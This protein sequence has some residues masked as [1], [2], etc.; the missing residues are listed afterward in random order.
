MEDC[1]S[2][3]IFPW[4]HREAGEASLHNIAFWSWCSVFH[5]QST[6]LLLLP[7]RS[8][9]KLFSFAI[10]C[11]TDCPWRNRGVLPLSALLLGFGAVVTESHLIAFHYTPKKSS[12]FWNSCRISLQCFTRFSFSNGKRVLGTQRAVTLHRTRCPC[13]VLST[14]P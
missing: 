14:A 12:N 8:L 13:K 5:Y 10:P 4:L 3:D 2:H 11:G 1:P 7:R 6:G 9:P